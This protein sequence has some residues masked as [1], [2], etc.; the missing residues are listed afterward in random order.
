[1]I[2]EYN[3]EDRETSIQRISNFVETKDE[4]IAEKEKY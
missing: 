2:V 4:K 1:M 3:E